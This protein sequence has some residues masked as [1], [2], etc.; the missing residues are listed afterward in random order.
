[1]SVLRVMHADVLNGE[2]DIQGSKNAVLPML[3]ASVITNGF[4]VIKRCP[5]IADVDNTIKILKETGCRVKY[6]NSTVE[7]D[8][9]EITS[10]EI[11][12]E[13]AGKLRSSI[14]FLGALLAR[15]REAKIAYPGGC[16]IGSRPIDIHI[17]ALRKMNVEFLK[18]EKYVHAVTTGLKGAH[19]KLNFPSV[20]ATQNILMCA[21]VAK[22]KTIIENYAKEPEILM[23]CS[24]LN[25]MGAKIKINSRNIIVNGV[26]KLHD[27]EYQLGGDRIVAGTYLFMTAAAGG[28]VTLN[29]IMSTHLTSVLK[30]LVKSGSEVYICDDHIRLE[31]EKNNKIKGLGFV[32]TEPF[33][34]FPTDLQSFLTVL[35]SLAEGNT[36]IK[37]NIFENRFHTATSLS[38]MGA[39]IQF[40]SNSMMQ[41]NGVTNLRGR[42]VVANDLRDAAALIMAGM[43]AEGETVI[44]NYEIVERGYE[45]IQ[46]DLTCLNACIKS[47]A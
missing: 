36:V 2:V 1:M 43:C 17:R 5:A 41:I 21:V 16:S 9:T 8:S 22:G 29:N 30:V 35:M 46:R 19:I 11:S 33:P 26:D 39:D 4:T 27:S 13:S 20:G 25:N 23:L 28:C 3:A 45:N 12:M 31:R 42:K 24:Y 18:D 10:N 15:N 38:L 44:D 40:L 6:E 14:I 34:G 32:Q 7:I 47:G 37:E